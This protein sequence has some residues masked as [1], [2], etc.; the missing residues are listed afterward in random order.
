M[1]IINEHKS[2]KLGKLRTK[3]KLQQIKGKEEEQKIKDF[4][5]VK[6]LMQKKLRQIKQQ[7]LC[8]IDLTKKTRQIEQHIS[9]QRFNFT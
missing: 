8:A 3:H 7:I 1:R 6:D 9:I 5:K 4:L 2:K